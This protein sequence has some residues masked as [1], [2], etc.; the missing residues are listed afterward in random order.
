MA[1]FRGAPALAQRCCRDAA[2]GRRSLSLRILL[3]GGNGQIGWELGRILP[4]VGEIFAFDHASLDLATPDQIVDRVRE[5]KPDLIVNAAAYT[6]VD[7]A[8]SEPDLAARI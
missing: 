4:S 8:E 2:S 5:V 3:T 1:R 7:R 6:A